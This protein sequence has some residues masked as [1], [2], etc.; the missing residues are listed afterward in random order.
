M[1]H[2]LEFADLEMVDVDIELFDSVDLLIGVNLLPM[3]FTGQVKFSRDLHLM[4]QST[5]FKWVIL[6]K[7]FEVISHNVISINHC[8]IDDTLIRFWRIEEVSST[9]RLTVQ[10][11]FCL[12]LFQ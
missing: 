9:S 10:E 5:V 12:N 6:R 2:Y 3:I 1:S 7:S 4:A 11:D 8:Q